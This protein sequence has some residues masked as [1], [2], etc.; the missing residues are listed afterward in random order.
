VCARYGIESLLVFSSYACG[1][2]GPDSDVDILYE[3]R[4]GSHIGWEIEEL[5]EELSELFGRKV[6]L[7][8]RRGLHRLLAPTVLAEAKPLYAA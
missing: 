6:D 4:P 5:A 1:S 2:A 8:A 7:V 3:L